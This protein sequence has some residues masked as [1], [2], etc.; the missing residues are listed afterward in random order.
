MGIREGVYLCVLKQSSQ[1]IILKKLMKKTFLIITALFFIYQI[2]A[3]TVGNAARFSVFDVGGTARNIGVG[4][5]LGALGADFSVLSTNPAGMAMYRGRE[6]TFSPSLVFIDSK[7]T[8]AGSDTGETSATKTNFNF[9]NIGIVF[10]KRPTSTVWKT[11]NFG[12]G[13]NRLANFHQK[14]SYEGT[15]RGSIVDRWI[16]IAETRGLDNFESG[17][18][19][20]A[21]AIR[22]A[23]TP[24]LYTADIFPDDQILK[25][26]DITRKGS[27]NELVFTWAGNIKERVMIGATLG[28]PFLNYEETRDYRESD[29]NDALPDSFNSLRY[30]ENIDISGSGINLKIGAIV[31]I[32]QMFRLGAAVHTPTTFRLTDNLNTTVAYDFDPSVDFMTQPPQ[33]SPPELAELKY[34][35][36]T[37]W[38]FIGSA[39]IV[40]GKLGFLTGEIEYVNYAGTEYKVNNDVE[41]PADEQLLNDVNVKVENELE[42]NINFRFGGE[43]RVDIFRFRG[44]LN[45]SGTPYADDSGLDSSLSL[46]AGV[47]WEKIF[48]DIGYRRIMNNEVYIPYV[49]D[50]KVVGTTEIS[51]QEVNIDDIR[52]KFVLTMG[53]RF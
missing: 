15:T 44:G 23:F 19:F 47:R 32:N 3:Q 24:G 37:P 6:F 7:S 1:S 46:G 35:L 28:I 33:S 43:A 53:V 14:I 29:P 12:M 34:N 16:E 49:I 5:G 38:R 20:D 22:D 41:F 18:A 31:R 50:D 45:L 13:L 26:Q 2:N 10:A 25:S 21:D 27:I 17:P 4:G 30:S 36:K 40:I 48:L 52:N 51:E 9:N 42:S 8:L 11:S 39:G